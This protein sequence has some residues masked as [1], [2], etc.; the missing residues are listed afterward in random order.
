[1]YEQEKT[2][3]RLWTAALSLVGA[4]STYASYGREVR[5]RRC[6]R[7]AGR[8]RCPLEHMQAV[9]TGV[10]VVG[11]WWAGVC[12]AGVHQLHAGRAGRLRVPASAGPFGRWHG[13]AGRPGV[14][15]GVGGGQPAAAH[16]RH[17][18]A[19]L[20]Q[21]SRRQAQLPLQRALA[22]VPVTLRCCPCCAQPGAL[23]AA[24]SQPSCVRHALRWNT[25]FADDY[26]VHLNLLAMLVGFLTYKIAVVTRQGKLVRWM[27][28]GVPPHDQGWPPRASVEP[29]TCGLGCVCRACR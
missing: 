20:Q 24:L 28:G 2:E 7:C 27:T 21:V 9:A 23:A 25:L 14:G 19:G 18:R 6:R 22:A 26:G 15:R 17:P 10:V 8:L 29:T 12:C 13:G 11:A 5:R 16:P 3:Q 4:A 1:M